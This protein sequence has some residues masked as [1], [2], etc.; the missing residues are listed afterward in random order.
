MARPRSIH[1]DQQREQIYAAAAALF[2]A[3]GYTAT[4]MNGVAAACGVSKATLYHYLRNKQDLLVQISVAHVA[5]LE[6]IVADVR[7]LRRAPEPHLRALIERFTAAYASAQNE[8]RVLTEDVR[9]LLP[10]DR[11][12]VLAGQRRVASAFAQA[13]AAVRPA[14]AAS[15]LDKPLAM[16]LLGM[17]NWTFTW[18]RPEGPLS[19]AELAPIVAELFLGGLHVVPASHAALADSRRASGRLGQR[20]KSSS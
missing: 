6:T 17:I 13:I 12:A 2:A 10:Q 3:R 5:R 19:H 7:Q 8:H 20:S 18:L 4:T 16:L 14:L 15:R 9:F 11:E 1:F